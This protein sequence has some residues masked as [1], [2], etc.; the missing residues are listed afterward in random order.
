MIVA[1]ALIMSSG[2]FK[3]YVTLLWQFSL[4]TPL[5]QCHLLS[6]YLN[7][8]LFLINL[9]KKLS[10][11][12]LV[13]RCIGSMRNECMAKDWQTGLDSSSRRTS[14][15]LGFS[16]L[17]KVKK[18]KLLDNLT[19]ILGYFWRSVFSLLCLPPSVGKQVY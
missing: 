14:T 11:D 2:S 16:L 10:I 9:V 4:T 8:Y 12:Y 7:T 13:I 19:I 18:C 5:P 15:N 1:K 17:K 6:E 3:L